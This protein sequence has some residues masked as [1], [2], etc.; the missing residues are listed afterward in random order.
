M[1]QITKRFSGDKKN[2]VRRGT[3]NFTGSC[4]ISGK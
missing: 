4:T 1:N 2:P 3:V